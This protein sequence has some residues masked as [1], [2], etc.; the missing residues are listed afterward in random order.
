MS[1]NTI[2]FLFVC[3]FLCLFREHV[4]TQ[5]SVNII[6]PLDIAELFRSEGLHPRRM[7]LQPWATHRETRQLSKGVFLKS[8]THLSSTYVYKLYVCF[9]HFVGT[10]PFGDFIVIDMQEDRLTRM[11]VW[12]FSLY[13]CFECVCIYEITCAIIILHIFCWSFNHSASV[14][15]SAINCCYSF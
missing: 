1:V 15:Y 2:A 14:K 13:V 11:S 10:Q 5:S 9:S 7:T 8:V 4:G 6:L 3:V 12:R